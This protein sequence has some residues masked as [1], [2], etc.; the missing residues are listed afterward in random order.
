M[1]NGNKKTVLLVEDEVIIAMMEKMEME[2]YG[3]IV[4]HVTTGE[5]AVQTILKEDFKIDLILMDIDLGSGID[6]TQAAAEILKHK[7]I[8]I[9]FLSSH[10]EPEVV[11]KT[12]K[13]TSYGYVVKNSGIVVLD[14][15]IKM[16][17]KLF[18]ANEKLSNELSE[19]ERAEKKIQE[20]DIRMRKLF[21]NVPDLIFQFTRRPDGSYYVPIASKGVRNIFGCSPE[22]VRDNFEPISRVIYPEDADRVIE[23]IEYSAKHLT[24]FTCEFRVH[25][26]GRDIQWILS[27]STPEKLPDGSVTWYGFNVDITE[28]KQIEIQLQK[29]KDDLQTISDNMLDLVAVTDMEGNYKFAGSS[30]T[31]LGYEIEYLIGKNVMD[32]VHPDDLPG[33]QA[34]FVDFVT[35]KKSIADAIYRNRCADGSYLWFESIATLITDNDGNQKEILFNTRDITERKQAEKKLAESEAVIRNKL[36]AITEPESDLGELDLADIIDVPAVQSL[37]ENFYNVTGCGGAIV[38][39]NGKVIVGV[40]FKDICAKFHRCH[41][42]TQKNC[43]ESDTILASGTTPGTFKSYQCKNGMWDMAAPIVVS[44]RHMGNIYFGQFFYSDEEPDEERF[45]N[46][47]RL[48]GF[49]EVEYIAALR[50]VPRYDREKVENII[51]FYSRLGEM[52]SALSFSNVSLSRTLTQR[53]QIEEAFKREDIFLSS[54][55]DNVKEAIIICNENGEII[56]F[57]EAARR[58]HNLPEKQIPAEQWAE[59]YDLHSPDGSTLLATEDIPLF[60]ALK[61]EDVI[62]VEIMVAP[63]DSNH[64]YLLSCNGCQLID[65]EGKIT[66]A[67]IT[68][69]DVTERKQAEEEIKKQLSEKETLLREVH[70]RVKNNIANIESLLSLQVDSTVNDEVKTALQDAISRIQSMRVLYEKLLLSKDIHEISIKNYAES[71]IDSLVMFFDPEKNIIIEKHFANFEV[72]ARKAVSIGIII[73]ELLT[74]VF[75][76]AFKNRDSGMVSVSIDKEGNRVTLIIQ[77][78][79]IGID[80]RID[81]NKYPGFGLT[82]V[83]MLVEQLKGTYSLANDN[84]T[85]SII[86]FEI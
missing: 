71:L 15:S 55:L 7:D 44:G 41:P 9:V 40:D 2:K 68:M 24:Y 77:D 3:Y 57:N 52:I 56:R 74:N 29:V 8:P 30:H 83:K 61:G 82:I 10:T 20:M 66:G 4:H 51:I 31:I 86:Q 46:Q 1:N 47:A 85:K 11:E 69:F 18:E 23:D 58:L 22:D 75:K 19:R 35:D 28:R 33:V 43:I 6:G 37:M 84:G 13:I 81:A 48:Y 12:E 72:D 34:K 21:A 64:H 63:K 59:Y 45:R 79:G 17:F 62:N 39:T 16:A 60:R 67:V 53:Q 54:V 5:N 80:E 27:R 38:D 36:K 14:T 32:F 73:N 76:Y 65:T 50:R 25:I 42:E 78:N 26:P 70:H 49:D